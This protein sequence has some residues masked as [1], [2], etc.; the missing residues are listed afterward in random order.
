[1]PDIAIET[2]TPDLVRELRPL[3]VANHKESGAVEDLNPDWSMLEKLSKGFAMC[4]Q[5]ARVDG[6]AV[7]YLAQAMNHSHVSRD[8]VAT[9]LAVYLDPGHR[10]MARRLLAAAEQAARDAGASA[11]TFAVPGGRIAD[12]LTVCGYEQVEVVLRKKLAG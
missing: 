9:V 12:W 7:G 3:I 11:F 4:L 6:F 8:L 2:L 5:V 10:W 1:V